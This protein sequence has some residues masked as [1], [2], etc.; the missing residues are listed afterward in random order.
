VVDLLYTNVVGQKPDNQAAQFY[1]DMLDSGSTSVKDL[2][3]MAANTSFNEVNINLTGLL[4]TGIDY[5]AIA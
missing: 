1:V 5:Q 4:T 2:G 3:W